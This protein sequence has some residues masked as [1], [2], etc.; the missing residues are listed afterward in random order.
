MGTFVGKVMSLLFNTP[1]RFVIAFLPRS[2]CLLISWLQSPSAVI[3]E[4]IILTIVWSQAKLQGGNTAPPI[5]R[6][7][8]K[9][10]LSMALLARARP[11]FPM[12]VFPITKLSQASYPH[13]SEGR[14]NE[15]HN[16]GNL[17]KLITWITALSNPVKL[18]AMPHRA[19]QDG[20]VMVESSDKTWST[21]EENGKPLQYSCL[22]NPMNSTKRQ[23]DMTQKYE[24][25][26]SE[27]AQYATE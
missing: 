2:K 17:T 15:N 8:M 27:D 22:E 16:H 25:P 11:I 21:G 1:S 20:R 13:P 4:P 23:K 6:N 12:P 5:S 18:W 7:W 10:L 3:L 26:R 24:L 14:Q 9:G 19:T